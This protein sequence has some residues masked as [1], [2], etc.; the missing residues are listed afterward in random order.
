MAGCSGSAGS[1]RRGRGQNKAELTSEEE[2]EE[3]DSRVV[4]EGPLPKLQNLP[5]W[6]SPAL[7]GRNGHSLWLIL[8]QSQSTY[9]CAVSM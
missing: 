9:G 7:T 1:V 8:A 3:A 2:A 6:R 4:A 5:G